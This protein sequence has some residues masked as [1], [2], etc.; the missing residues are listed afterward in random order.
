MQTKIFHLQSLKDF[1]FTCREV[2]T[3]GLLAPKL[4]G[5]K[6]TFQ[7][8]DTLAALPTPFKLKKDLSR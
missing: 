5:K 8:S 6:Q 4:L 1:F 3:P 7:L 2:T